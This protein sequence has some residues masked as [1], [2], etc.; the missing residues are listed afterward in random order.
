[1]NFFFKWESF[2]FH[3]LL[4]LVTCIQLGH[5]KEP[6]TEGGVWMKQHSYM[7]WERFLQILAFTGSVVVCMYIRR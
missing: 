2:L 4:A 5:Y 7:C 3:S 6:G 1:M